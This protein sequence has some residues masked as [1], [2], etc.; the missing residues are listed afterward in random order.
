MPPCFIPGEPLTV[1]IT[2]QP[3][4]A[5]LAF[6]VEEAV[7]TGWTV[8]TISDG[9][10]FDT[11]NGKVKWGPFLDAAARAVSYQVTPPTTVG[12]T[13]SFE[14]VCSVDGI[15]AAVGGPRQLHVGCRLNVQADAVLGALRWALTGQA[16]A[17]FLIEA[18]ADLVQW[19]PLATVTNTTGWVE[20]TDPDRANFPHRFYRASRLE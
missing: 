15:S 12:E 9:G 19:T 4:G 17:R 20:F 10:E 2:T 1:T 6:A 11:V 16:G 13:V 18:S 3:D 14:G 5:A 8:S 7:P